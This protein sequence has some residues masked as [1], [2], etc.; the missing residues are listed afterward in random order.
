MVD[1]VPAKSDYDYGANYLRLFS[2]FIPRLI[3][4]DKPI[5]GREQWAA[6][7]V[8]GS[9]FKRDS[10]F[11]GPAIGI[12]GA[13][14]LNGGS[15]GTFLVFSFLA[16]FLRSS[17]EYF[18]RYADVPWVQAWWALTFY[19]AWFMTV[20]DDPAIWFYYNWGFTTFPSLAALWVVNKFGQAGG[21]DA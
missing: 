21:Q 10:T 6:A 16:V 19:N 13:T 2:T 8:A 7:W 12:L 18:R 9:E 4:A 14:Q 1:T 11:T 3:W 20:N 5:Y 15:A 17:Y